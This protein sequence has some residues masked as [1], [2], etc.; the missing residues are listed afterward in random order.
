MRRASIIAVLASLLLASCNFYSGVPLSGTYKYD[1]SSGNNQEGGQQENSGGQQSAESSASA[2]AGEGEQG[3]LTSWTITFR[4]NGECTVDTKSQGS[5]IWDARYGFGYYDFDGTNGRIW[6]DLA[7][8]GGTATFSVPE[9]QKNY[10]KLHFKF[11]RYDGDFI[12]EGTEQTEA[13]S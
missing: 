5:K 10:N 6:T 8:G 11:G 2:I 1:S 12:K 13:G 4:E 7:S 9:G 3:N